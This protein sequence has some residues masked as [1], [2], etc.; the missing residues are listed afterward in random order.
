MAR[1]GVGK[2]LANLGRL[3]GVVDLVPA[4]A[5]ADPGLGHAL[6]VAHGDAFGLEG[7]VARRGRAGVEVLVEP[8][9]GRDDQRAL[10]PVVALRLLA[11]GPH[12]AESLAAH[13]DHE[14]PRPMRVRLLVGADGK[15]RDVAVHRA[16]GHGEANMAPSRAALLR[17][18]ERQVHGVGDEIGV[19]EQSLLLA[20]A[21]E[22]VGLAVEAILEV[23]PGVEDEVDV[24][25][26]VDDRWRV[27]HRHEARGLLARGIEV[28]V[29]GVERNGEDRPGAPFERDLHAGVVPHRGRAAAVEDVD[30]LLEE[31]A[32]RRE[33]AT[34]RD[35]AHVGVVGRP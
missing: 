27:G 30:H 29:A 21:G 10:A 25:E 17:G 31:L 1:Q 28:L 3:V 11:F 9:V 20:L 16:A 6:G 4:D 5:A 19:E 15:L 8:H 34:G 23:I 24:A 18:D 33:L 32:L 26:S 12:E 7:E 2:P 22:V 13:H 35:L 14:R